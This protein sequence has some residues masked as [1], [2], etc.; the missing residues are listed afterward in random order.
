MGITVHTFSATWSLQ[1]EIHEYVESL[2]PQY[3]YIHIYNKPT[4]ITICLNSHK[5][6]TYIYNL[7]YA[8]LTRQNHLYL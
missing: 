6:Q 2:L 5:N 8:K 3:T 4:Y 7:Q 1:A